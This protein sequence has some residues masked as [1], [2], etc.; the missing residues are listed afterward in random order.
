MRGAIFEIPRRW[1]WFM[2]IQVIKTSGVKEPF[3]VE[4][5]QRSL[6]FTGASAELVHDITQQIEKRIYEGIPTRKI[7]DLAFS[8]LRKHSRSMSSYYGTKKA[9]LSLG[10]D[11]FL[12]EKFVGVMLVHLGFEVS[13]NR[14]MAGRCIDHEIDVVGKKENK[15]ILVECK[16]HNDASRSNDIKTALYVS[17]R[18]EDLRKNAANEF[19]E[20]WLIT[21]TTFS[22]DAIEYSACAGLQ[23]W[24]ANFPPQNTIQDMIRDYD[25]QP[26]TCLTSLRKNDIKRLLSKNVLLTKDLLQ[27]PDILHEL[28]IETKRINRILN[29]IRHIQNKTK[30]QR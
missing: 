7:Y 4:K 25:L 11:G 21:N 8:L 1:E 12:F 9:L 13:T 10:P 22:L 18:S 16:F 27:N 17:A 19:D 24:G 26:V 5:L 28:R 2:S 20:F 14:I 29:E 23:L 15:T 6:Q 3:Q 30:K